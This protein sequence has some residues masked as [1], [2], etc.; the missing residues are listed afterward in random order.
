MLMH[1]GKRQNLFSLG[2]ISSLGAWLIFRQSQ[3]TPAV[4]LL[5]CASTEEIFPDQHY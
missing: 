2:I 3:K 4:S 5:K 1:L